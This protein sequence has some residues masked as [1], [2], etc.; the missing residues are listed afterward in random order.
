M[1]K[2]KAGHFILPIQKTKPQIG[3]FTTSSHVIFDL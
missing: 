1:Q 2:N 3:H